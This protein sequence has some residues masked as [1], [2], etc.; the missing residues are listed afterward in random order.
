ML[1]KIVSN[2][3]ASEH[4]DSLHADGILLTYTVAVMSTSPKVLMPLRVDTL[5][6]LIFSSELSV[7]LVQTVSSSVHQHR[8]HVL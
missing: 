3:I 8:V 6:C 7:A 4:R 1:Y 5:M 2:V